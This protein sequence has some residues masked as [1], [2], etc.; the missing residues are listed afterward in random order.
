MAPE[1]F[2]GVQKFDD[3]VY[4]WSFG[5]LFAE[6]LFNSNH[7]FFHGREDKQQLIEIVSLLGKENFDTWIQSANITY[8][9]SAYTWKES[10]TPRP[11]TEFVSEKNKDRVSDKAFEVL[12]HALR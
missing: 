6:L 11:W 2:L 5:V 9:T 8:N 10:K 1:L 3:K 12:E 4:I 7:H